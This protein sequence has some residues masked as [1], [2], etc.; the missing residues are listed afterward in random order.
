MHQYQVSC[1]HLYESPFDHVAPFNTSQTNIIQI[2]SEKIQKQPQNSW[3]L[4]ILFINLA[5]CHV[6]GKK[7]VQR[8]IG[9][10]TE[11]KRLKGTTKDSPEAT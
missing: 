1:G 6:L 9:D 10:S 11:T 4:Y 3:P 2:K 8:S 7:K 5:F